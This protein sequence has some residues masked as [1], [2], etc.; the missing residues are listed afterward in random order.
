MTSLVQTQRQRPQILRV[1][2]WAPM[3]GLRRA[4]IT[5][6]ALSVALASTA[7]CG[8]GKRA[9]RY[10]VDQLHKSLKNPDALGVNMGEFALPAQ[11]GIIDGDTIRVQGLKS[12]LRLLGID[13][14]ETFKKE[15]NRA[16]FAQGWTTYLDYHKKNSHGPV[17]IA[18]PLG[19]AAKDFAVAFFKGVKVVRLERDHP[20][21]IKGR[22]GR[23]LTYVLV[24][25]KGK[26]VNYN[27]E[28]V[29]AGMSPYFAKYSYSRRY[30][31]EF[32]AAQ[33]EARKAKRGIWKP[34]AQHYDDYPR[35]LAWWNSRGDFIRTF[36]AEAKTR[37]NY[38]VL[39]HWDAIARIRAHMG[40][41]VV[42]LATVGALR[43]G[44]RG[45]ARVML[46]RRQRSDFPLIFFD[47]KLVAASNVMRA[48]GNFIRV[49]GVVSEYKRRRRAQLQIIVS[50]PEQ[51]ILPTNNPEVNRRLAA[52]QRPAAQPSAAATAPAGTKATGSAPTAGK[53]PHGGHR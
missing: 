2:R 44:R 31:K 4:L 36:E 29:R 53:T 17:K 43:R 37:S 26:W 6:T 24:R 42:I 47:K 21:E 10:D 19:T 40:K 27:V 18:T 20:K 13:T 35:R 46:S 50:K 39:T 52:A 33:E 34:G 48:S 22:F 9:G 3:H 23:Y 8:G 30:H 45:P 51:I 14:E 49:T 12:T 7:G 16:L 11:N 1:R 15:K 5:L 32:A 28:C 38:I 41:K 25:R